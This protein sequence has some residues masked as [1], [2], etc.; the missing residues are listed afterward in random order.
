MI[1]LSIFYSNKPGSRFDIDYYVGTHNFISTVSRPS[2][3][4]GDLPQ[5]NSKRIFRVT[6]TWRRSFSSTK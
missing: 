4:Y 3:R 2:S 6:P 5:R 1:K